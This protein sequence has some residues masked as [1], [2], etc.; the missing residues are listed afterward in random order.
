[1]LYLTFTRTQRFLSSVSSQYLQQLSPTPPTYPAPLAVTHNSSKWSSSWLPSL[2]TIS[3]APQYVVA[4]VQE[5]SGRDVTHPCS[6]EVSSWN[7]LL[8]PQML[9]ALFIPPLSST[10]RESYRKSLAGNK[11]SSETCHH[12]S[13]WQTHG[14][15]AWWHSARAN[16]LRRR[17]LE[18]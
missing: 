8:P 9:H 5:R 2:V 12:P 1:M 3:P 7:C 17:S 14:G 16:G 13:R 15:R 11:A 10:P 4:G 6:G 18:L